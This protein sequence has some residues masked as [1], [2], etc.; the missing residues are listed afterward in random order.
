MSLSPDGAV[1][2]FVAQKSGG[3]SPQLYVRRL[4]PTA[5]HGALSGTDDADSPFFSPDG[6]WIA[7]FAGGKLKKIS[8]TGG[9]A[10]TLCDAPNGRG[11]AW[12]EDGTIVFLPNTVGSLMRVSSAGGTRT[13]DV[14]RRGRGHPAVA[15]GAAGRQGGALYGQPHHRRLRRREPRGAGAADGRADGRAARGLS[16]PLSA[17]RPSGVHPRRDALCGAL[18]S[19]PAGGDGAAGARA[20]RRGVERGLGRRAVCRVGQRHAGV[21]AGAEHRRR[22]PIHWMDHE[23]KTTPLRATPANWFNPLFAPDGRRLALQIAEGPPDIWVYEWARDTL[24]RLTFD[25]PATR[26]RCGPP[27]A[28][29]SCSRRNARTNRRRT[30]IGSGPMGPATRSASRRARTNSFPPR[31]IRAASSWRSRKRIRQRART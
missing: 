9:A 3:G 23:G 16:R 28:A 2:A 1:I 6:Q 21:S 14:P 10:V 15:A 27:M 26:S 29:A 13:A 19:R 24:T 30:C 18:R 12:S 17:E 4:D 31:G 25:P 7:F 8:V 5:G 22:T 11:G 20:R